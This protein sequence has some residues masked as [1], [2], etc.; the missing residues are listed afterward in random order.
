MS[1][2]KDLNTSIDDVVKQAKA[3]VNILKTQTANLIANLKALEEKRNKLSEEILA[4]EKKLA[5][6]TNE[7][8]K[9]VDSIL[10][11][12]Q[13]KLTRANELQGKVSSQLAD[14]DQKQRLAEDLIK[15]NQGLQKNLFQQD[16]D[17][18]DKVSKL[19]SL[20]SLINE[21]LKGL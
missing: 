5:E 18:S 16:K 20:V 14:L 8:K 1:R 4:G 9:Q 6:V 2:D 17:I 3:E 11:S 21:T 7:Y 15:S 19:S 12:A 13:E 10:S